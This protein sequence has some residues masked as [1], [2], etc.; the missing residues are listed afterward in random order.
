MAMARRGEAPRKG[1]SAALLDKICRTGGAEAA[2]GAAAPPHRLRSA[3][4]VSYRAATGPERRRRGRGLERGAT[5]G[6]CGWRCRARPPSKSGVRRGLKMPVARHL[7]GEGASAVAAG[8]AGIAGAGA[9][10]RTNLLRPPP[11]ARHTAPPTAAAVTVARRA[12]RRP[13]RAA[14]TAADLRS[15][16]APPPLPLPRETSAAPPRVS[17]FPPGVGYRY[18]S[19]ASSRIVCHK[20]QLQIRIFVYCQPLRESSMVLTILPVICICHASI[21]SLKKKKK[22]KKKK[23]MMMMMMM[24]MMNA[25]NTD[26]A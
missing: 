22:K 15:P 1:R 19:S 12:V 8:A 4:A 6:W 18:V 10:L 5:G 25:K 26:L 17:R 24:M 14:A 11:P 9:E 23:K 13:G 7:G 2:G 20:S 16:P 3:S 21:P